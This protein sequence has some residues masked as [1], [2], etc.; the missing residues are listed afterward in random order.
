[1]TCTLLVLSALNEWIT[2]LTDGE[3][4]LLIAQAQLNRSRVSLQSL[5]RRDPGNGAV[6][7]LQRDFGK[8]FRHDYLVPESEDSI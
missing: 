8:R 2:Q 5:M 3:Y 6:T 4:F 7:L 1:M